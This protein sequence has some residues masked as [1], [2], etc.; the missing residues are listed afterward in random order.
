MRLL[1]AINL[2]HYKHPSAAL[3]V[4]REKRPGR[5]VAIA[6]GANHVD[7]YV[8]KRQKLKHQLA[9]VRGGAVNVGHINPHHVAPCV[10]GVHRALK[11]AARRSRKVNALMHINRGFKRCGPYDANFCDGLADQPVKQAAFANAGAAKQRHDQWLAGVFCKQI[12][13]AGARQIIETLGLCFG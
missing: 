8:N 3:S 6:L 2:V 4:L 12:G 1:A 5:F 9:I 10:I 7:Q 13:G 11:P